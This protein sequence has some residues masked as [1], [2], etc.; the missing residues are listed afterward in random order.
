MKSNYLSI[1]IL[2]ILITSCGKN[3]KLIDSE[4][5]TSS[6]FKSVAESDGESMKKYYP[7]ISTFDSYFKSD[8]IKIKESKFLNDSLISVST[9]NYF[10]NGFGKNTVK[11]I[12]I[13]LLPDSLNTYSKI[14]DS[15][16][17]TDHKENELYSFGVKTG[18]IK[19]TDTTDLQINEKYL[20]AY[21][22]SR[23][24]TIDKLIDFMTD[25]KVSEWSWISGYGGS[26]SGKGIVRNN[27]V[28]DIPNIK[29]KVSY[30]DKS[31]NEITS[32]DGYV[33]YDILGAGQSESFTFYTSYVSNRASSASISLD[34]DEDI[35]K[36]YVLEAN[37]TG[38][39][40]EMYKSEQLEPE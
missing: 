25:V 19:K 34:F 15:K 30:K 37:Y 13:Y 38:N 11:E 29:Y 26:A 33:T 8:S 36:K 5:T 12:E 24:Y 3:Q 20:D 17:M 1:F 40:Y 9:T 28:F 18:C 14:I 22:L 31:G 4:K 27:T 16:G 6:F 7:N 21:L 23:T 2:T 39:E 35:I 10:T 32:D